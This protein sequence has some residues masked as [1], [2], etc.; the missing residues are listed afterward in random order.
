MKA[1]K[2]MSLELR[3]N[4]NNKNNSKISHS[5]S[6]QACV[7]VVTAQLSCMHSKQSE[8]KMGRKGTR[9]RQGKFPGAST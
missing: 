6:A 9:D 3:W 8:D 4:N 2:I 5:I 1:Q 7:F